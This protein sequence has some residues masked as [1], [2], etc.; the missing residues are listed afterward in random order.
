MICDAE[1]TDILSCL[2]E[3]LGDL[4]DAL[5]EVGQG[6]DGNRSIEVLCWRHGSRVE[7]SGRIL[8]SKAGCD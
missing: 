7:V 3:R 1:E 5:I 6:D 2:A 4:V 8:S